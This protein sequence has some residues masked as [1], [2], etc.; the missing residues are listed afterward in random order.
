MAISEYSDEN[1]ALDGSM[2]KEAVIR[3]RKSSE[4]IPRNKGEKGSSHPLMR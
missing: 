2:K 1:R 3:I 4:R